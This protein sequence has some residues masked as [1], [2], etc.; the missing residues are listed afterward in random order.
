M[1]T[2]LEIH[3]LLDEAFAGIEMTAE[4][5]DLKEEMR[6]NLGVRVSE[7][8]RQGMSGDQ[9]ARR[10]I[11]EL[12]DIRSIVDD[13]EPASGGAAPW[14]RNRVRPKPGY[15]MRTVVLGVVAAALVA[16]EVFARRSEAAVG[17]MAIA[18]GAL[19]LVVG[20]IVA[21]ALRQETT[22][23]YPVPRPRA[24]GYGAATA[25]GV[26]G[27]DLG[28]LYLRDHRMAFVVAG[29]LALL[30][31]AVWFTYLGV[32]QTNRHKPWVVRLAAEHMRA[33]DRFEQD[34]AAAAR[35][36]IYTVVI[37]IVALTAFGVLSFTVGW[38]WSWLAL[39]AGLAAMMLTLARMLFVPST[40]DQR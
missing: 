29:G 30:L 25:V 15:V 28:A 2:G 22:T 16:T 40:V 37:W 1:T 7:L 21:D 33:G 9:A 26:A 5:Q 35:F 14:E 18:A 23:N 11:V 6:G 17:W 19:G 39:V 32:T 31:S 36:G 13:M 12:G 38:A 27:L 8:E 10:A 20:V 4:A 3:R 34:P 24:L